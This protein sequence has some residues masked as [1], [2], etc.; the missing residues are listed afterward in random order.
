MTIITSMWAWL[1]D[2]LVQ[3]WTL[4]DHPYLIGALAAG[5]LFTAC[6]IGLRRR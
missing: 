5:A 2:L 1:R 3:A 4:L 6:V